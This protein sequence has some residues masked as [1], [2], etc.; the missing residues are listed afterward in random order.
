MLATSKTA[1][2]L[3]PVLSTGFAMLDLTYS[4]FSHISKFLLIFY[5]RLV[6]VWLKTI[7]FTF[8]SNNN[9]SKITYIRKF[10]GIST[11]FVFL[12]VYTKTSWILDPQTK[13]C[14][15]KLRNYFFCRNSYH[16]HSYVPYKTGQ[17]L[18]FTNKQ[19]FLHYS[20]WL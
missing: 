10:V 13:A 16:M 9:C 5:K 2:T 6:T 18:Y 8:I 14:S 19:Y 12:F 4:L 15:L 11:G 7:I 3:P 1:Q 17:N 20:K